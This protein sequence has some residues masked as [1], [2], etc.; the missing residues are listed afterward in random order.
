MHP[1]DAVRSFLRERHISDCRIYAA[2]SGG[3]D[4]ICL[5]DVLCR[6]HEEYRLEVCA[7][8]IQHGLRGAESDAD[9]TF[10]RDFCAER[11]IPLKVGTCDVRAYAETHRCSVETAARECRYALFEQL[12]SDGYTAT[13]H[14]ASDNLETILFRM[15]RGTGLK[16]L[17]GIP[18]VRDGFL[19][20]LLTVTRDEVEQY[21][22]ERQL[23]YVTDS[24]NL[25]D[26]YTR[27][28]LRLHVVP[29]L[30][31]CNPSAEKTVGTMAD[32]LRQEE[33]FLEEA[34]AKAYAD[35]LRADGGLAVSAG[36]HPALRRRCIAKFLQE[37]SISPSFQRITDT[38]ALLERGGSMELV[39]NGAYARCSHGILYLTAQP[40][41]AQRTALA[42]GDNTVFPSYIVKASCICRKD[43]AKFESVHTMFAN[44]VLDYDIIKGCAELH[45]RI[46]GLRITLPYRTHSISIKKW[47]NADVPLPERPYVHFLSDAEGLLWVQGLGAAARAA[48]TEATQR[49]LL[50]EIYH[51][52]DTE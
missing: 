44:S 51:K 1:L 33:D 36:L 45:G 52:N 40:E 41:E 48:V 2:L 4:S 14:T 19:R 29:L 39:R 34:A 27:N 13:A 24:S 15:V 9:E 8:H 12:C 5:L 31:R 23:S 16:G 46:P 30:R 25:E 32:V 10:C 6:L 50:L 28:F 38:E 22:S 3:A 42:I 7:V 20:P 11:H 43:T 37:N 18:P 17:G 35:C 26:A 47:L 21:L 49:M